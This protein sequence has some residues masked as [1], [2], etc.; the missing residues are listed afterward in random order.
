[1]SILKWLENW[2]KSNCNGDWEH[3]YGIKITTID[4]P[5]WSVNIN[6]TE[7]TLEDKTFKKIEIDN[8]DNDWMVCLF[9]DGRFKGWGDTDKLESIIEIFKEW[10]E[11]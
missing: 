6:L 5:G 2:Y 11:S 8:G 7:T 3:G 1:M 4:N 10:A 9:Q